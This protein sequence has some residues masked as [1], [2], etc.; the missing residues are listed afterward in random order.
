MNACQ[1]GWPMCFIII[2]NKEILKSVVDHKKA[3]F[4]ASYAHYDDCLDGNFR[5]IPSEESQASLVQDFKQMVKAGMFY[6]ATSPAFD[7][8]ISSLKK[9]ESLLN[10]H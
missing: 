2:K 1:P 7:E 4:N 9:L 3:F 6:D 10:K 8:I 5:L